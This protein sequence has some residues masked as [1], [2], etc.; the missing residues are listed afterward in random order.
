MGELTGRCLCG[1]VTYAFDEAQVLW[2]AYCHCDSCR[3][4]TGAPVTAYFGVADGHWHWTGAEP[5]V[6]ASSPGVERRFCRRC[7][8]PVSYCARRFPGE[9]HF[10][11]GTLDAPE[12]YLPEFHVHWRERLPWLHIEDD[13]LRFATTSPGGAD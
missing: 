7:G 10:H 2:R 8:S 13:L 12:A 9:M 1:A 5:R 6:Y 4:A 3:R 11:A